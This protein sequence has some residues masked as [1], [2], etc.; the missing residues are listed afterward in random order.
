[1]VDL[2]SVQAIPTPSAVYNWRVYL[3]AAIASF[4]AFMIGYDSAFIGTTLAL[5]AFKSE[6]G[7]DTKST[8]EVN[9]L[10]A[11]IVSTYQAGSFFGALFG[12]VVGQQLGRRIGLFIAAATFCLGAGLTCGANAERGLSLIYGGRVIAGFGIGIAS[13]LTPIYTA[14]ISPPAIRGRLVGLYEAGWQLGGLLGF[15]INYALNKTMAPSHK[16]WL[17]PFAIQLIPGG[18]L[19]VGSFF[20]RESPRW[21]VS[22]GRREQA[23]RNLCWLRK[24]DKED[25]YLVDEL[26][27][28]EDEHQ[29]QV[30]SLGG[31]GFWAPFRTIFSSKSL[32]Y[33]LLLGMSLFVWQNGS[34]INAINYYSPTVFKSIGVT[35]TSTS[36]FTTGI[37]GCIKTAVTFIWLF[38]LIDHAG[39]RKLL[40]IGSAGGSIAMWILGGYIAGAQPALH[41]TPTL[42]SGG[43]AAMAFF[44]IWT[45]FYSPSWNGTPWVVNAEIFDTSIRTLTQAC[46]SAS[47]WFWNFLISRFTP[48]M[49]TSMVKCLKKT[50]TLGIWSLLFLCIVYATV[51]SIC[52][53]PHSRNKGNS[54]GRCQRAFPQR[55][56]AQECSCGCPSRDQS[57]T[58]GGGS[59]S[60]H[61]REAW[62]PGGGEGPK[63]IIL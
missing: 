61:R 4:A 10:N 19:L 49:F 22:K 41:P 24:L 44:Y 56:I 31:A 36:L 63:C 30:N 14:E 1:M 13:N 60:F 11:N 37:F 28:M 3:S 42:S 53:L 21:L 40:L 38:F 16:Q 54:L 62:I 7:L 48:Q 5:P 6:F 58:R 57:Q 59:Q 43:I 55:S 32:T 2:H 45:I 46:A 9:F 15:W 50:L 52:L 27:M 33:R 35:G 23:T 51:D 47:N 34:G 12:Y 20:L 25:Q 26:N 17:I 18:I 29:R 8:S 39:R